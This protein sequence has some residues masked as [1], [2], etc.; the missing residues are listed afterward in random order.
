MTAI[1]DRLLLQLQPY[2]IEDAAND[3][4]L[5]TFLQAI[6]QMYEDVNNWADDDA[7]GN[8]GWSILLDINRVPSVAL[9][10]LAQFVGATINPSFTDAQQRQQILNVQGWARGSVAALM[11][12]ALPYLT[13]T[14]TIIFRERDAAASPTLPAYGLTILTKTSETPNSAAVLAALLAVKP[15]G[16]IL[17]YQT[18]TGWDYQGLF[19]SEATYTAL[20]G[21]FLTYQ[22]VLSDQPG[23]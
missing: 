1:G 15:A 6:G 21:A 16:I 12:A 20:F 10:W 2:T 19:S 23:T 8:V 17:N 5:A 13:D 22:G 14:K 7:D 11:N 3:N 4:A 9:P 18:V